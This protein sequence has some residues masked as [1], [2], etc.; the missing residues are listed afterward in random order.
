M[1]P[2]QPMKNPSPELVKMFIEAFDLAVDRFCSGD[3]TPFIIYVN[4]SGD[5]HLID[6]KDVEGNIDANLVEAAREIISNIGKEGQRYALAYDSYLTID[7]VK[8]D[9]A[10]VEAAERGAP[11]AFIIGQRYLLGK[12][13][14]KPEKIGKPAIIGSTKQLLGAL[15]S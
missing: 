3:H 7:G 1:E 10:I 5:S 9:A 4:E 14:K 6:V 12:R 15:T 13:S 11:E 2:Y 8:T